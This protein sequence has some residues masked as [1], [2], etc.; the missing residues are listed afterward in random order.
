VGRNRPNVAQVLD[1]A[2]H[3]S[4]QPQVSNLWIVRA[5][6][7]RG[8]LSLPPR[9][10]QNGGENHVTVTFFQT[11]RMIWIDAV[12]WEDGEIQ[13]RD[14]CENFDLS[15]PQASL[16]LRRYMQLHPGRIAYDRSAKVYRTIEGSKPYYDKNETFAALE[17]VQAVNLHV[18]RS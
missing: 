13:R 5:D 11:L 12:L 2:E 18:S 10:A 14:I 1:R 15:V 6:P 8:L 16:D 9:N 17:I 7:I 3:G 4:H